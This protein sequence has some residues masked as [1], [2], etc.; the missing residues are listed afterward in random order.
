MAS[1]TG[2]RMNFECLIG[3]YREQA[4]SHKTLVNADFVYTRETCG[5][6][7]ARDGDGEV[8]KRLIG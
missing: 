4:R 7:L 5:S 6:G 2:H 8:Y 3:C 1:K